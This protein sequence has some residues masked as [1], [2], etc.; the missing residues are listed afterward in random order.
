MPPSPPL[1]NPEAA[2]EL[3]GGQ[4]DVA[5]T[6]MSSAAPSRP[7]G[8]E[9]EPAAPSAGDRS[10][11]N[12]PSSS[13]DAAAPQAGSSARGTTSSGVVGG[14]EPSIS[15][16][17]RAGRRVS[18]N[19]YPA[20]ARRAAD[21]GDEPGS[22]P[23][24]RTAGPS[25]SLDVPA[26]DVNEAQPLPPST[27]ERS[28]QDGTGDSV[29][30]VAPAPTQSSS[31][32]GTTARQFELRM[33]QQPR[34]GAELGLL[35]IVP[36]PVV[37]VTVRNDAG[38]RT[39]TELPF[40][41]CSALLREQDG[42]STVETIQPPA[43]RRPA[44]DA[45]AAATANDNEA[46][47]E[48]SA[49]VGQ[50]VRNPRRIE[51]L[52]GMQRSVFVFEDVSVRTQGTY[53]LEFMLGEARRPHS[54]QLAAIVSDP[55]DVVAWEDYPGLSRSEIVPEFSMHLHEQ[56]IPIWM[57]PLH[58]TRAGDHEPATGGTGGT[59]PSNRS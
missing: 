17:R 23:S 59:T 38:E 53:R 46:E 20:E 57:P 29:Q 8:D 15:Q 2:P 58:T 45:A 40:L 42:V 43:E 7:Q 44:A 47:E 39:D 6:P 24:S 1:P 5:D 41:F 48:W 31:N 36:A 35:P 10:R 4:D 14:R 52:D 54:P 9:A 49:L 50:L 37:E 51:D 3:P 32:S 18:T 27:I 55:F 13:A 22:G 25:T 26:S 28:P 11:L 33:L 34:V 21:E 16:V 12:P 56:G 19:P 30:P